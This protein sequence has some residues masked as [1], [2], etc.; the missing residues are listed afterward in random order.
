MT[1]PTTPPSS[2]PASISG[3]TRIDARRSSA[4]A[5]MYVRPL[6]T[7]RDRRSIAPVSASRLFFTPSPIGSEKKSRPTALSGARPKI[8]ATAAFQVRTM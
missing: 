1:M 4:P 6:T 5:L 8:R 7:S 3:V 2:P